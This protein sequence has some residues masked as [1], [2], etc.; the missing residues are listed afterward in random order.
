MPPKAH[1]IRGETSIHSAGTT[2][3]DSLAKELNEL[4]KTTGATN[5]LAVTTLGKVSSYGGAMIQ[6]YQQPILVVLDI[7]EDTTPLE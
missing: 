7:P 3:A 2:V 1:I 5:I 6:G 4:M